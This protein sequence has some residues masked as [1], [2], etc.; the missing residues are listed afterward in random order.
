MS[1]SRQ[2]QF[3]LSENE[4][5]A[6]HRLRTGPLTYAESHLFA[7]DL[8]HL[9]NVMDRLHTNYVQAQ[10]FPTPSKPCPSCV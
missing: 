1:L 7:L 5:A 3:M 2:F 8:A 6:L 4:D 10:P 9:T